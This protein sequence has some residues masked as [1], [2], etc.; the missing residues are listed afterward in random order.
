MLSFS[1]KGCSVS[2]VPESFSA[3][4]HAPLCAHTDLCKK[5][6]GN[7]MEPLS[8]RSPPPCRMKTCQPARRP[9]AP[10]LKELSDRA[11]ALGG[12]RVRYK[13]ARAHQNDPSHFMISCTTATAL[14]DSLGS[15]EM[16]KPSCWPRAV[17][18]QLPLSAAEMARRAPSPRPLF[19]RCLSTTG[20]FAANCSALARLCCLYTVLSSQT[21]LLPSQERARMAL[22]NHQTSLGHRQAQL[23]ACRMHETAFRPLRAR[24]SLRATGTILEADVR[25]NM[26][27]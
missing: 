4:G 16:T 12:M 1:G 5:C 15:G 6:N 24:P 22:A 13:G 23:R 8:A 10:P 18:A 7:M 3:G 25:P 9:A 21:G 2:F 26:K 11:A 17:N 14:E 27:S 20:T 19:Q